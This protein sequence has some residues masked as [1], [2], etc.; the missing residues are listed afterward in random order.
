M[1]LD[2]PD[3]RIQPGNHCSVAFQ[4]IVHG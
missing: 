2:A 4:G 1:L 3:V